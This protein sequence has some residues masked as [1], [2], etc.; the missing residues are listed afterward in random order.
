MDRTVE[1]VKRIRSMTRR[2]DV[3]HVCIKKSD[4]DI[5]RIP[6]HSDLTEIRLG[7]VK[8]VWELI[9][10]SIEASGPDCIVEIIREDGAIL[11]I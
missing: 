9:F 1:I 4:S 6:V 11:I 3:T 2:G 7:A 10:S 8:P 5:L